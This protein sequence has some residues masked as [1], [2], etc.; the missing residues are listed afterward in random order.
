MMAPDEQETGFSRSGK[1]GLFQSLRTLSATLLS[2]VRTRLELLSTEFEEERIRLVSMLV[3]TLV[4][5]FCGFFGIIFVT[6]LLVIALW[7]NHRLLA[8]GIPA[9]FFTLGAVA[10]IMVVRSKA[11]AKPRVFAAS[12]NELA[13][14]IERLTSRS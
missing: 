14:D 12:L 8:L 1:G 2:L 9:V 7:D 10:S 11:S 3:W 4:G 6:L 5:L 13:Q